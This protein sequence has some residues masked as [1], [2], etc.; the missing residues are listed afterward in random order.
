MRRQAEK[1]L[2]RIGVLVCL[3]FVTGTTPGLP[4]ER[5]RGTNRHYRTGDWTT[6][7]SM[8]YIRHIC[9]APDRVY[10]A[11]TGGIG[12][13]NPF[14]QSWEDPYT[15]SSGLA[16]ADI[17][18]VAFDENSGYLWCTQSEGISYLGPAT[19]IWT[20][21]FYD[22]IGL[23][24]KER[25]LSIGFGN[26]HKIYL[27]TSQGR[28]LSAFASTGQ[29]EWT[30][31]P[32]EAEIRWFGKA[33]SMEPPPSYL[34]LP[35]GLWYNAEEQKIGDGR[36]R[37]FPLTFWQR[38]PW[39]TLWIAT[40]GLGAAR[41]D[42]LTLQYK[43]LPY[44]LWDDAV[45]VF[46]YDDNSLWLGGEQRYAGRGGMTRWEVGRREP[47]YYEPRYITGFDDDRITAMAFDEEYLW[48]GTKNGLTRYD[49][50]R[51]NWR[52]LSQVDHLPDPRITYLCLDK[53]Y[54]WVASEAGL[55]RILLSSVGNS[56]SLQVD[57]ID[58]RQLGRMFISSL[59]VQGDTLWVGTE[60]GLYWYD[61]RVDS[62]D[63]FNAGVF[64][65]NQK[66]HA[67]YS[68][69]EEVWFGTSF[70][71]AGFNS[72]SGEWFGPPAQ[73]LE[74]AGDIYWMEADESSIWAATSQGVLRY[75]RSGMR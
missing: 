71:I 59:A 62:G 20:N 33:V 23:G 75:D 57:I 29:F 6:W 37:V 41:A 74:S 7:S 35:H 70:G 36:N 14:S 49:L 5:I 24:D 26:D 52:T 61:T 47:E 21:L 40:W 9:I 68:Y 60:F 12:C 66:I 58:Q 72:R 43:P 46:A 10:F 3:L 28:W 11:T 22:E 44:G 73:R 38:D 1:K 15:V 54:V 34:F 31:P 45:D 32:G 13:Y 53:E 16:S 27:V 67:L 30:V 64:P 42:Q 39:N 56:D 17:E 69:G 55:A 48:F 50:N 18:L 4:E 65:V 2:I 25:A 51:Q 19:Q 8:R 63:F